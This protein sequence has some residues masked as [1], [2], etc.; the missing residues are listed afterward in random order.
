M[1][2]A[3]DDGGGG[4]TFVYTAGSALACRIA[5]VGAQSG[6]IANQVNERTTHVVTVPPNASITAD[7]RF[8]VT[9]RG[10]YEVTAVRQRTGAPLRE[11][12]VVAV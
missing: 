6:Q 11:I 1:R 8:A 7:D 9:G 2:T 3:N 5:P 10:T 4:G 12:E